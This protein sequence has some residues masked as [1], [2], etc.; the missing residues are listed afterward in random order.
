MD[1]SYQKFCEQVE[2]ILSV[3]AKS[4]GYTDTDANGP[5]D[6]YEFIYTATGDHGH[7]IGEIMYKALRYMKKRNPEDLL[8]IA[9]W[10]YL[11]FKHHRA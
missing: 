11:V 8:K 9:A 1:Q 10:A 6:V 2:A 5:N 7:P 4:K 3:S